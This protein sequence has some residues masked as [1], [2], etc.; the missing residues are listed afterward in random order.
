M[1]VYALIG[2]SGTGK[3]HRAQAVAYT[4]NIET[5][6]DDG[7]LIHGSRI[8][9]GVSAK[10]EPTKLQAI[11]RAIFT[12]PQ[13]ASSV[14]AKLAELNPAR[15]LVIATS[16]RMLERVSERL[17][18]PPPTRVIRIE[19]VATPRQIARALEARAREGKHVIPVP[20]IEVKKNLPGILVDPLHY[21]FPAPDG[22]N[23]LSGGKRASSGLPSATSAGCTLP[24]APFALWRG[25][26]SGECRASPAC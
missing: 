19:E 1:E 8:V 23:R 12:D 25:N 17:G 3:S 21:F 18:L 13:H 24:K 10:R 20:T 14:R 9:A 5:I 6:L 11:R 2:P 15:L 16:D 7:L 26:L 22:G 4:H